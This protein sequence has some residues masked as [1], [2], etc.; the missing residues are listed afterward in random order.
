MARK[1]EEKIKKDGEYRCCLHFRFPRLLWILQ[2]GFYYLFSMP[3]N[4]TSKI[5]VENGLILPPISLEP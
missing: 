3:S 1:K 2:R 4:S 5:N